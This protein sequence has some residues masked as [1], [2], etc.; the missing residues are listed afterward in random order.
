MFELFRPFS[1]GTDFSP[2]VPLLA[3]RRAAPSWS[4]AAP[5][6]RADV[7]ETADALRFELDLPGVAGDAISI[8]FENGVLAIEAERKAAELKGTTHLV[9]ERAFGKV[10]RTFSIE[11]PIDPDKIAAS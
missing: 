7:L 10:R 6:A 3:P 5:A 1:N 11:V 8:Q 2:F 9:A 4:V